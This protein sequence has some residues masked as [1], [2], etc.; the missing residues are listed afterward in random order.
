MQGNCSLPSTVF[1]VGLLLWVSFLAGCTTWLPEQRSAE[2][3]PEP[4]EPP[5][6]A[7]AEPAPEPAP[8][9]IAIEPESARPTPISIVLSSSQP[10][11]GD[12]AAALAGHFEDHSVYDLSNESL[13]PVAI[14]RSIN[15]S[16]ST[17]V[18][19]IGLRAAEASVENSNVPVIFSQVFNYQDHQLITET[20]RGVA[21]L[22]PMAAQ[23]AAW[24]KV[25]PEVQRIG[26]IV[27]EGHDALIESARVAAEE[28]AIELDIRIAHSD[29]ETLYLFRR[30]IG[31]IDGFWLLPDNRILSS[32]VLK[33]M[34]EEGRR[35]NVTVVAPN[36]SMLQVG[37]AMSISSVAADIAASIAKV[38]R[39]IQAGEIDQVPSLTELSEVRVTINDD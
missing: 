20:S 14:I 28:Q 34:F 31:G 2:S 9:P 39:R 30:M 21:A 25:D 3:E 5:P 11:Y 27:G 24:K 36:E 10:A 38:L 7:T 12:I 13:P 1:R 33:E 18:V 19:A 17:A 16:N 29:Q 15:D 37:A 4:V 6:V 32:R 35:H 26:I 22:P 8:E 23:L